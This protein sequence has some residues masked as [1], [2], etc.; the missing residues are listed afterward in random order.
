MPRSF[1]TSKTSIPGNRLV[2]RG[3]PAAEAVDAPASRSADARADVPIL[4][5]R[6]YW[7]PA[8]PSR[9]LGRR[10]LAL[11]L[12]GEDLVLFRSQGRVHALHDRCAHRG[13]PLSIGQVR[14]PGTVTCPYH[15]WTFDG[16]GVCV[17]VLNEGPDSKLPGK[18]RVRSYPVEE[19]L[20]MVWVFI[21]EMAP[22]PVETDIPSRLFQPDQ[23]AFCEVYLWRAN[24]RL[25]IENV[26]DP[27]HDK[28]V[29]RAS[30]RT[31]FRQVRMYRIQAVDNEEGN[32]FFIDPGFEP[33][34]P[35]T[36]FP[37]VGTFP[38]RTWW[39]KLR[40]AI[41]P[42]VGGR[43]MSEIRLPGYLQVNTHPWALIQWSVPVDATTSRQCCWLVWQ[44]RGLRAT[45]GWVYWS[46]IYKFVMRQFLGQDAWIC[47]A[48]Q[49]RD[50]LSHPEKLSRNDGGV[51]RW[52]KLAARARTAESARDL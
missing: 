21:G 15:G 26:A 4:G 36:V 35:G 16:Q 18:A 51:I 30:M 17:A 13:T 39:R 47:N 49:S 33:E 44:G 3:V 50:A 6:N 5:Y 52:R 23:I 9:A 24:W 20:G 28:L 45:L 7:Y 8:V 12:L 22:P 10:P 34:R 38:Q 32:G 11:R 2:E 48:Q 19:R 40:G 42:T 41:R 37:G 27:S 25:A 43:F 31:F 46:V 1:C 14:F 29:H